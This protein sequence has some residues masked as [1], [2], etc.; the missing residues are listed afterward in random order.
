MSRKKRVYLV[1]GRWT[2]TY[3]GTRYVKTRIYVS[4]SGA[5]FRAS[6]WRLGLNA[7]GDYVSKPADEVVVIPSEP[8]MFD[9]SS[10]PMSSILGE[11]LAAH[12]R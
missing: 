4:K 7:N 3:T 2:V 1:V 9:D 10:T 12:R 6:R 8:L 11:L 5:E